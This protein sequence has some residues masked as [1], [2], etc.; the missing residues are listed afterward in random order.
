MKLLSF[1]TFI[2]TLGPI[3]YLTAPGTMAT[4]V[5]IPMVF[6]LQKLFPTSIVYGGI[7]GGITFLSLWIVHKA[8]PYFKRR[9]DPPEIVLDELAG[10]LITFW[11]IPL[12]TTSVIIGLLLFRFFDILKVGFIRYAEQLNGSWGIMLDDVIAALVA[13]L[14]LRLI[15]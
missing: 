11:A 4:I 1:Y 2:A 9:E 7:V 13:N 14:I 15:F 10:C 8:Q 3:G 6:W 5:T 12:S